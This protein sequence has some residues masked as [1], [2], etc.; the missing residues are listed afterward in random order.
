MRA[1]K[2]GGVLANSEEPGPVSEVIITRVS[3]ALEEAAPA[4]PPSIGD[5]PLAAAI[6]S[7]A[8]PSLPNRP[9][10]VCIV[11]DPSPDRAQ[12]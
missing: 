1:L 2:P 7:A 12:R 11:C 4:V 6:A 10:R 9:D 3:G 8:S 5:T